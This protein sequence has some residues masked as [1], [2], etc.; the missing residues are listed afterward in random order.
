M[1]VNNYPKINLNIDEESY[2][3]EKT[4]YEILKKKG[5]RN[6]V[7][8]LFMF[9]V[10]LVTM[11]ALT[12]S[13]FASAEKQRWFYEINRNI[14]GFP[15]LFRLYTYG[16]LF[17][18]FVLVLIF[19]RNRLLSLEKYTF[20]YFFKISAMGFFKFNIAP[21]LAGTF[22]II[23]SVQEGWPLLLGALGI[24][25]SYAIFY[26]VS[27]VPYLVAIACMTSATVKITPVIAPFGL[28]EK[29]KKII[30][31][32]EY[33]KMPSDIAANIK[34]VDMEYRRKQAAG[35]KVQNYK[36]ET[37]SNKKSEDETRKEV[38]AE[39]LEEL[40]NLIGMDILKGEVKKFLADIQMR[41]KKEEYGIKQKNS[42]MHMV[43][44]GPPGTG[45]T[46]VARIMGQIL[47]GVGYLEG[48]ELYEYDRG[49]L[50]G[51]YVGQTAPKIKKIFDEAK[52]GVIFIDEAYSL[53]PKDGHG[54]EN[55]AIDTIVKLMEDN[56]QDTVVIF[57]GYTDQM[58][59][60]ID[61]NP[62]LKSRVPYS[63]TF[64][65]YSA[66][67]LYK[68]LMVMLK[69]SGYII[70]PA[71]STYMKDCIYN[72]APFLKDSNGR[73]I[74]NFKEALYKEQN[75]RLCDEYQYGGTGE[76]KE[77]TAEERQQEKE[78]L[79]TIKFPEIEK[80]FKGTMEKLKKQ[81]K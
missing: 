48:G 66:E 50:I 46:T 13:L 81:M 34:K 37:A 21:V 45:K 65:P 71:A 23:L 4:E 51:E 12:P 56:R 47:Y 62:G 16:L 11:A 76:K 14:Y 29:D 10:F 31:N 64:T 1:T 73:E 35:G 68:I 79:L 15:V 49:D 74:R 44:E 2:I 17:N 52:G 38:L 53:T 19:I 61:S 41:K 60:F 9:L 58:K 72:M 43:F 22:I 8:N 32:R 7:F 55:E 57:A 18:I 30:E 28:S 25:I 70:D 33:D 24:V 77:I 27:V 40:H 69:D 78:R 63:F 59:T 6:K 20:G 80:T 5:D 26:V 3:K 54:F 75:V 42:T 39:A 67:E 36:T